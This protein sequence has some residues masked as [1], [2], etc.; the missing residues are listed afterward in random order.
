MKAADLIWFKDFGNT[1]PKWQL[2]T[3]D[4]GDVVTDLS[5]GIEIVR[6][7]FHG[8][9]FNGQVGLSNTEQMQM[10]NEQWDNF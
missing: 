10:D 9:K 3:D 7:D 5:Q 2:L 4:N 6:S 8:L 1:N